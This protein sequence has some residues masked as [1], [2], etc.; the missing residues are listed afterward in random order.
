MV[1][2]SLSELDDWLSEET[3]GIYPLTEENLALAAEVALQCWRERSAE[4]SA[5]PPA[6]LSYSC[7]FCSLYAKALF[8]G[9]IRG[10]FDHQYNV[11]QGKRVDL[12]GASMDVSA[13]R[14]A[15]ANPYFH[16]SDFFGSGDHLE[17]LL[18][19]LPRVE[20]WLRTFDSQ[21]G[22]QN[23][24]PSRGKPRNTIGR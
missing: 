17:S 14:S 13:I 1:P 23:A 5:P 4:R 3:E 7:K 8:G 15:G 9:S 19:C 22:S 6:D 2:N 12:S 20:K 18:S 16:D 10:N 24:D 21:I 11:I